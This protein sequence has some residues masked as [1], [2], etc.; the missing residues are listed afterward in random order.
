MKQ[1]AMDN[2]TIVD[3]PLQLVCPECGTPRHSDR[4][5]DQWFVSGETATCPTCGT[6]VADGPEDENAS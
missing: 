2:G 4:Y 3:G 1:L 5:E 6:Q